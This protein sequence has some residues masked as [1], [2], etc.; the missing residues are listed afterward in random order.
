[1]KYICQ[2][3]A[4]VTFR[5]R[6]ETEP[7]RFEEAVTISVPTLN[8]FHLGEIMF[9]HCWAV[10]FESI[11]A[12]VDAFDQPGVEVYK[13]LIGPKLQAMKK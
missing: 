1:M 9:M 2:V 4:G 6:N 12:G 13:R 11:L 8:A 7:G 10:Y 5:F 3:N